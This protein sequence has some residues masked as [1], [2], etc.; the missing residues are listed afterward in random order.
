MLKVA[1]KILQ[2][3]RQES[4]NREGGEWDTI[5]NRQEITGYRL[6]VVTGDIVKES[7]VKTIS[8]G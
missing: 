6:L 5:R 4:F 8:S 3:R 7:V 1:I 2:K